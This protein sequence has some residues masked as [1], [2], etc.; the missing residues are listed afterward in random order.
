[1]ENLP[2]DVIAKIFSLLESNVLLDI[3]PIVCKRWHHLSKHP[4][5]WRNTRLGVSM[6]NTDQENLLMSTRIAKF[7]PYLHCVDLSGVDQMD[8]RIE[9]LLKVL[10]SEEKS[11]KVLH[12]LPV[13]TV[14]MRRYT[15]DLLKKFS[16]SLREVSLTFGEPEMLSSSFHTS[17]N[18]LLSAIAD[19][20]RMNYLTLDFIGITSLTLPEYKGQL[21]KGC[22]ALKKLMVMD[23]R[24]NNNIIVDILREKKEMLEELCIN[25]RCMPS[26]DLSSALAGCHRLVRCQVP[27]ALLPSIGHMSELQ[28]LQIEFS[29]KPPETIPLI[30]SFIKSSGVLS[31]LTELS[32]S[33]NSARPNDYISACVEL[34]TEKCVKVHK[35]E[36]WSIGAHDH[37]INLIFSR[38]EHLQHLK[39]YGARNVSSQHIDNLKAA[40][41]L[42]S[43]NLY[44]LLLNTQEEGQNIEDS[45]AALMEHNPS[46]KAEVNFMLLKDY[47]GM[48]DLDS[49]DE[50]L[51]D[52]M[53][54]MNA[55]YG[56]D[57]DY[58][59]DYNF[60]YFD[61]LRNKY[62]EDLSDQDLYAL[63]SSDDDDY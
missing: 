23:F 40:I 10:L 15:K 53:G 2:D 14:K 36:L 22:P 57:D 28:C 42:R 60:T 37:V 8:P 20:P 19:I 21:G 55:V 4:D 41:N 52:L 44:R 7:A 38:V 31:N 25:G 47:D 46:L 63:M 39:M 33:A 5:S 49:E 56:S 13:K 1:M 27:I 45:V 54:E 58:D 16:P 34:L 59:D 51:L 29:S 35:L 6:P 50:D 17:L 24:S 12:T 30:N 26:A 3:I 9:T 48:D 18:Q 11:V 61:Y 43:L 62:G 32:L